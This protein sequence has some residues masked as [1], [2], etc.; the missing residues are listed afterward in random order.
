LETLLDSCSR[1]NPQSALNYKKLHELLVQ[2]VSEKDLAE[3]RAADLYKTAYKE[4]S[5]RFE[6]ASKDQA[7]KACKRFF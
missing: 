1:A 4:A 3:V 2:G 6:E 7:V 5:D